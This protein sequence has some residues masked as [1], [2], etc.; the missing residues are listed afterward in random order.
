MRLQSFVSAFE[1]EE[2]QRHHPSAHPIWIDFRWRHHLMRSLPLI[3]C[4]RSVGR[5]RENG[6]SAE[7][8]GGARPGGVECCAEKGG[9]RHWTTMVDRI[10]V[11]AR[12]AAPAASIDRAK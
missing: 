12:E 6:S 3:V 10:A 1:S 8:G 9:G 2:P 7:P 4:H 5:T 11:A